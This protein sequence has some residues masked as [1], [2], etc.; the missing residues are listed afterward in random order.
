MVVSK[1]FSL[2]KQKLWALEVSLMAKEPTKTQ[3]EYL[4]EQSQYFC[5][6]YLLRSLDNLNF[7]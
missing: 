5:K 2:K 7:Y 3:I 4:I 1:N 6:F